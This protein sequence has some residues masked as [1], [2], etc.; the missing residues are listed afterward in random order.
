MATIKDIAQLAGVSPATVSRVLNYDEEL[1]V[2]HATKKKIFEAA[3]ELNYTKH[4]RNQKKS[5][6]RIVLIQWYDEVEELEDL[7]Y[8]SIR[9]GIEKK[10]EELDLQLVK[11]SINELEGL[12][13]E[14]VLAL[15]KFDAEQVSRIKLISEQ[16]LF[17]DFDGSRFGC[18]SL[19]VDFQQAVESVI[20]LFVDQ[21]MKEIGMLAGFEH[22]KGTHQSLVDKRFLTFQEEL[23]RLG[24]YNEQFIL[25]SPFTVEGGYQA[26]SRFLAQGN[27]LPEAF[28]AAN[29]ALAI[30]ALKALQEAGIKVPEQLSIVG[31]NDISVAK[32]V[33]PP[34]S[35]VKVHTEWLGEKSVETLLAQMEEEAPVFVKTMIGT[36][37]I[38]RESTK[39]K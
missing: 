12:Q 5:R 39:T 7:Y 33:S 6:S 22:T 11:A 10:A 2:A 8:L 34:L 24:C 32:Y 28:F 25:H 15:G 21:G 26:M 27:K 18:N 35:T 19:V 31:F 20:M 16:V 17:V 36:E 38:L 23:T 30:G 29:D 14:G 3:E 37:L 1:S 9:L 13:A 4:K